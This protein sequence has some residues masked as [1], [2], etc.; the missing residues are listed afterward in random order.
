MVNLSNFILTHLLVSLLR[1]KGKIYCLLN[2]RRLATNDLNWYE[3][4]QPPARLCRTLLHANGQC[5]PQGI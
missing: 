1:K 3:R 2:N 5:K 4:S